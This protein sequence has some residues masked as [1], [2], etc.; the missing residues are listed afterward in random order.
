MIALFKNN[1]TFDELIV[2]E[3]T[4]SILTFGTVVKGHLPKRKKEPRPLID[5]N[6]LTGIFF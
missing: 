5:H 1:F 4:E 6:Q 3:L 2:V